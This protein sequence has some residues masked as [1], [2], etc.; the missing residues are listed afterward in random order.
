M[1][2]AVATRPQQRQRT[3]ED[4]WRPVTR[5]ECST[6]RQPPIEANNFELKPAFITMVSKISSVDIQVGIL[7]NIWADFLG[8]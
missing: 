8:W 1:L 2:V 7:K 3:M 4:F 5:K 6:V